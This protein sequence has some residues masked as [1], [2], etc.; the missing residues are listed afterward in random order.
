MI[1]TICNDVDILP[2]PWTD[3]LKNIP[4]Q[5]W[6]NLLWPKISLYTLCQIPHTAGEWDTIYSCEFLGC[7]KVFYFTREKSKWEESLLPLTYSPKCMFTPSIQEEKG[8]FRVCCNLKF[9]A[10]SA[11]IRQQMNASTHMHTYA[12]RRHQHN[13]HKVATLVGRY[14]NEMRKVWTSEVYSS[15]RLSM[16][17]LVLYVLKR[18]LQEWGLEGQTTA[19]TG[20]MQVPG[21][22]FSQ[23]NQ[24]CFRDTL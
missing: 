11:L 5:T 1:C 8:S 22:Q 6:Q 4:D 3:W 15:K 13:C 9:H 16:V 21:E 10:T 7:K 17:C 24:P 19:V 14:S 2:V 12:S 18:L 20:D 23:Q